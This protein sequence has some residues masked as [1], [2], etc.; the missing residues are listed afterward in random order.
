MDDTTREWIPRMSTTLRFERLGTK[1]DVPEV[2]VPLNSGWTLKEADYRAIVDFGGLRINGATLKD[3]RQQVA[4]ACVVYAAAEYSDTGDAYDALVRV[5]TGADKLQ[6][7][8]D[9]HDKR[10]DISERRR[11]ENAMNSAELRLVFF[12]EL[13]LSI[14]QGREI[15]KLG[16]TCAKSDLSSRLDDDSRRDVL[17]S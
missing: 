17:V 6:I 3:E 8:T 4:L 16:L 14:Y 2:T 7:F 12:S 13:F 15:D 5:E 11:L 9:D 10:A 1:F